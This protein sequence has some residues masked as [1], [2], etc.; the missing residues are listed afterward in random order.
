MFP[1][2]STARQKVSVGQEMLFRLPPSWSIRVGVPQRSGPLLFVVAV[3]IAAAASFEA[4]S[5][6]KSA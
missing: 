6:A 2:R 4:P 3:P 1:L 5:W